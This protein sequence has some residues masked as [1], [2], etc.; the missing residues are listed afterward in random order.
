MSP[1]LIKTNTS[2][3]LLHCQAWFWPCKYVVSYYHSKNYATHAIRISKDTA[4]ALKT[5]TKLLNWTSSS[6]KACKL[7]AIIGA[8][9]ISPPR[10]YKLHMVIGASQISTTTLPLKLS[11]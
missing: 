4:K 1:K 10:T 9:K 8:F 7:K 2:Q 3:A 5:I 6:L 11:T